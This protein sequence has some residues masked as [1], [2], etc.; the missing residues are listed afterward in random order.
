ML[1]LKNTNLTDFEK[2]ILNLRYFHSM[3]LRAIAVYLGKKETH[4]GWVYKIEAKALKKMRSPSCLRNNDL[5]FFNR[6]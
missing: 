6:R 1:N 5:M 3:T 4:A 2:T